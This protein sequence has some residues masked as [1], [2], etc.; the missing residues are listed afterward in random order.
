M[1]IKGGYTAGGREG[2][3]DVEEDDFVLAGAVGEGHDMRHVRIEA[4]RR[5][6]FG[7]L[8]GL[9]EPYYDLEKEAD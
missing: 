3:V 6:N 9:R 8:I 1:G 4:P 5:L 7:I 2:A